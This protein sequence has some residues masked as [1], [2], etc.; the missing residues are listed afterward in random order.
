MR[1]SLK[2]AYAETELDDLR[3]R[4]LARLEPTGVSNDLESWQQRKSMKTRVAILD[5]AVNCL[6]EHGYAQTTTKL[7]ASM[8]NVSRGAMLHHYATRWELIEQVLAY[9]FFKRM[10][11][12]FDAIRNL[13]E[14]ER[15]QDLSGVDIYWENVSQVEYQAYLELNI[16]ARTDEDLQAILIPKAKEFDEIQLNEV[17]KVFPEWRD[18]LTELALA[19]DFIVSAF[20]GLILN[21]FKWNDERRTERLCNL[22]KQVLFMI[23]E[24]QIK[25]SDL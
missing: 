16:A 8:A 11:R 4:V 15:T 20:E 2:S 25:M 21:Q 17:A 3:Q 22:V 5:A 23:R 24:G 12:N 14:Q 6:A 7:V 19:N 18:K 1:S 10:E 13:T 9:T